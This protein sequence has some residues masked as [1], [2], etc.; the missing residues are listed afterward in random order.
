[1]TAPGLGV[2]AHALTAWAALRD[3]LAAVHAPCAGP[4]RDDW[5]GSLLAQ[6]RAAT[7]CLDCPVMVE[8]GRYA[9]TAGEP[10]GTWGGLT[11]TDRN[12]RT[13]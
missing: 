8:C 4:D 2:P 6:S 5:T 10:H 12:R 3:A 13:A 7:A 1:M 11:A 9:L